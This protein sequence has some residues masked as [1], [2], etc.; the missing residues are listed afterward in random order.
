MTIVRYVY[1][2]VRTGLTTYRTYV[3]QVPRH[4]RTVRSWAGT[5]YRYVKY[6]F[7]RKEKEELGTTQD[8]NMQESNDASDEPRTTE[9]AKEDI[10]ARE[11]QEHEDFQK[12][13][14]GSWEKTVLASGE[15]SQIVAGNR[16]TVHVVGHLHS[17][18]GDTYESSRD[19]GVPLIIISQRGS[20]VPGLDAALLSCKEGEQAIISV[21][22]AGAYGSRGLVDD[23]GVRKIPGSCTLVFEIE[24]VK[25]EDE[26]EL[27]NMDFATKMRSLLPFAL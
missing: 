20:L 12:Q 14:A 4:H 9:D 27:W 5:L 2:Y 10:F 16:V 8:H 1:R 22:P 23:N 13:V 17:L 25:V 7:R 11:R 21:K 15:G 6:F 24:V 26:V 18:K 19:R 3:L